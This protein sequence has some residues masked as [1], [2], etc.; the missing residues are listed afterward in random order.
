MPVGSYGLALFGLV[1]AFVSA[2]FLHIPDATVS[3]R[4]PAAVRA[5]Q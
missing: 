5:A 4:A 3:A 1:A 2:F